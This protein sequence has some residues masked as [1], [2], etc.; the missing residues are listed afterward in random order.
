MYVLCK[1]IRACL[2]K[3]LVRQR[4]KPQSDYVSRWNLSQTGKPNIFKQMAKSIK[5]NIIGQLIQVEDFDDWWISE[6]IE[7]PFF[8]NE[9]FSITFMDFEPKK[10]KAFIEEADQAL[11]NFLALKVNDRLSISELVLKNCRDFMEEVGVDE[12]GEDLQQVKDANEI[13]KF[14]YPTKIYV[15][16]RNWG[17]KDIYIQIACNC[18]WEEEHGLQLVFKQGKK[19]TRISEQDGHLT[20]ADAYGKPDSEDELLSQFDN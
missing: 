18:E 15:S 8:D 16:R 7:I 14:V 4:L 10:D 19:L 2:N 11:S 1:G 6:D 17:D 5:S 9:E 20:E 12:F 13:W 3:A